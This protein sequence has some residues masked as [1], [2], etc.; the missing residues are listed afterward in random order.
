MEL[1]VQKGVVMSRLVL[2]FSLL[3]GCCSSAQA[4]SARFSFTFAQATSG[5]MVA[6][7]GAPCAANTERTGKNTVI[8]SIKVTAPPK[9]GSATAG[10]IGVT[11]RS[12]P[13]F[14]GSDSFTFTVF[15]DGT[16]GRNTTAT[17]QMNV[18]VQ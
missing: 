2:L 9:N 18:T 1:I 3:V 6:E 8:K 11:Y 5:T 16:A 17:I 4:C 15:G 14:K 10:S 12:K 13:G 7:S